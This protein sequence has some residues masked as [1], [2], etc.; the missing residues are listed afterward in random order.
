MLQWLLVPVG[1][2]ALIRWAPAIDRVIAE[3][4]SATK[5][6][7]AAAR[8]VFLNGLGGCRVFGVASYSIYLWHC[9]VLAG[10]RHED[11]FGTTEM[12]WLMAGLSVLTGMLSW[13]YIELRFYSFS[14]V[15]RYGGK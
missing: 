3:V 10:F 4:V 15:K 6:W 7:P 2:A 12:W 8:R 13:K 5:R 9:L 1:G 14:A 11:M